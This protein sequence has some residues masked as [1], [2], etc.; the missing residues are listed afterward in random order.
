L[1]IKIDVNSFLAYRHPTGNVT[2][3]GGIKINV[4]V[5]RFRRPIGTKLGQAQASAPVPA[6]CAR[7]TSA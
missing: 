7:S 2:V 3:W 6:Q 4:V 5:Q 1:S